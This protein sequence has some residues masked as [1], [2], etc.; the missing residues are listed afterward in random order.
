MSKHDG[1]VRSFHHTSAA[2]YGESAMKCT[3][4]DD[5]IIIGIYHAEGGTTGEF[6]VRWMQLGGESTPQ[7]QA[8]N[9]SWEVLGL[10]F[11]DLLFAMAEI[12]DKRVTPDEFCELLKGLGI[13]DWTAYTQGGKGA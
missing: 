13:E 12:D 2:W 11:N 8:F 4:Y 7:L 1:G 3:S 6:I 9:D 5:E 10:R